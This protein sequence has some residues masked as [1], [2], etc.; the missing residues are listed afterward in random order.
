[1]GPVHALPAG[2]L[3]VTERDDL[4]TQIHKLALVV[5][6]LAGEVKAMGES[7][8]TDY[9]HIIE[10]IEQVN[11]RRRNTD[12]ILE[13][14]IGMLNEYPKPREI[15]RLQ[16]VVAKLPDGGDYDRLAGMVE[17]IGRVARAT[18]ISLAKL[19]VLTTAGGTVGAALVTVA[20]A[21]A[22]G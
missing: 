8:K 22:G 6:G 16:D 14:A 3:T 11:H 4:A 7:R 2:G 17:D 5:A 15:L 1:M 20:R 13:K 18:E 10:R 9:D 12:T 19:T 21:I